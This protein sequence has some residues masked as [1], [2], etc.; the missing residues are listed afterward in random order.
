MTGR[1]F[2]GFDRSNDGFFKIDT[3]TPLQ[4]FLGTSPDLKHTVKTLHK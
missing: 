1:Q 3:K 4:K 2:P